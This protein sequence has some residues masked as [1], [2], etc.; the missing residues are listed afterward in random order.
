LFED[1]RRGVEVLEVWFLHGK[2]RCTARE[3]TGQGYGGEL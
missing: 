2:K 1:G 3:C